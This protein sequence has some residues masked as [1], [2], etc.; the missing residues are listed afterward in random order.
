MATRVP[1]QVGQQ[2]QAL[3]VG[4]SAPRVPMAVAAGTSGEAVSRGAVHRLGVEG[5]QRRSDQMAPALERNAGHRRS[6]RAG[7]HPELA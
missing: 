4:T 6:G 5:H 3:P 7:L 1:I 2:R